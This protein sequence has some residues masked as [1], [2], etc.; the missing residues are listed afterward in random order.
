MKDPK[1]ILLTIL[2]ITLVGWNPLLAQAAVESEN[3]DVAG[4]SQAELDQ[5]LAP[6]ALY[7]DVLLSQVLMAATYPLEV[8]EASRWTR[9]N[10]SLEGDAAVQ[11]VAD[12]DWDDSIKALVGF[13][14]LI[15][16]MDENLSWTRQLGDAFLL[17]EEAVMETVQRLRE[18]A[19]EQGSLAQMDHVTVE[20]Q[21][22]NIVIEPSNVEVVY[23]PY[24]STR[25]VYGDWWWHDYPPVYWDFG[26]S[27]YSSIGFHWSRGFRVSTDFYFSTCYWPRRS[28][29]VIDR[30]HYRD[31]DRYDFKRM[32]AQRRYDRYTTNW[33]HDP[34]HRRGVRYT[35]EALYD[36]YGH[37]RYT[38]RQRY[39]ERQDRRPISTIRRPDQDQ[40]QSIRQR[41]DAVTWQRPTD[42]RDSTEIRRDRSDIRRDQSAN[43]RIR[44]DV[45]RDQR[46]RPDIRRDQ[47]IQPDRRSEGIRPRPDRSSERDRSTVVTTRPRPNPP[48]ARPERPSPPPRVETQ[49]SRSSQ[50][51]YAANPRFTEGNR[52]AT[53]IRRDRLSSGQSMRRSPIRS[54]DP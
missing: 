27:Y 31:H 5:M 3:P 24:Y 4:Y 7:P 29:V 9:A 8:V 42:R 54:Q 30:H 14:D 46:V 51:A 38:D 21:A 50:P 28:V 26:P 6:I 10:P 2:L 23:V 53:Q 15:Q 36:R 45:Q 48:T 16:L 12:E 20:R 44:P 22:T 37:S 40:R 17:Q 1:R 39:P 35:H 33:R 13:P 41:P 34:V 47:R 43:Q 25:V 49:P 19:S 52:Q 18:K 11:A 32:Q